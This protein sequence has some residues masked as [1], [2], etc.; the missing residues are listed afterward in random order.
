MWTAA[1]ALDQGACCGSKSDFVLLAGS[2]GLTG[3]NTAAVWTPDATTS[4][5]G[6]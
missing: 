3:V 6:I 4:L 1:T 2:T 5:S